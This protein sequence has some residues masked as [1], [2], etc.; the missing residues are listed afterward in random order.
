MF[1][2]VMTITPYVKIGE[3]R[4]NPVEK[5]AKQIL[6]ERFSDTKCD[7]GGCRKHSGRCAWNDAWDQ[8]YEIAEL[9]L[10]PPPGAA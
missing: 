10:A 4:R 5:R 7:R 8:A 1:A 6:R 2:D 3:S 9:E